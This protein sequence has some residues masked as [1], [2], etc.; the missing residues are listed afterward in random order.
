MSTGDVNFSTAN[1]TSNYL[2]TK[3]EEAREGLA[4]AQIGEGYT[5]PTL[6]KAQTSFSAL[7]DGVLVLDGSVLKSLVA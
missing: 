2:L 5:L 6:S 4:D 1:R 3:V 7:P